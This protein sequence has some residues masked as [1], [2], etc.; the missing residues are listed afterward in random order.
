LSEVDLNGFFRL[1]K[2]HVYACG[3][4]A[5][6]LSDLPELTELNL[7]YNENLTIVDLGELPKL[8]RLYIDTERCHLKE[9]LLH[10]SNRAFPGIAKIKFGRDEEKRLISEAYFGRNGHYID[11]PEFGYAV[12]VIK[13]E[14]G[15][16]RVE[17][18]TAEELN[19]E[20][21]RQ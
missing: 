21:R 14:N 9:I 19:I 7:S 11:H 20:N 16:K 15:G 1:K 10:E 17:R 13:Y 2:L 5:L 18:Y 12:K 8:K 6:D 4:K 3:V